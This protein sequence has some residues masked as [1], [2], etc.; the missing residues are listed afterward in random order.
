MG[1]MEEFDE[2]MDQV[3]AILRS[4]RR[5]RELDNEN[6]TSKRVQR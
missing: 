5:K 2:H 6:V 4:T 3:H 1:T